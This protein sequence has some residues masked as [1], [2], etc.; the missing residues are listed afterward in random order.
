[1]IWTL[2][3]W[4][5]QKYPS[6]VHHH[7]CYSQG[8]IEV[9]EALLPPLSWTMETQSCDIFSCSDSGSVTTPQVLCIRYCCYH[10]YQHICEPC[11]VTRSILMTTMTSPIFEKGIKRALESFTTKNLNTLVRTMDTHSLSYWKDL[12]SL[13]RL[14]S[15]ERPT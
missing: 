14:S 8:S 13:L 12:Q 9:L 5:L 10:D 3:L 7:Q 2:A 11:L 1:M 4:L 15:A 6:F